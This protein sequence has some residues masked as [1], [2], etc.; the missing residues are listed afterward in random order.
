MN[1]TDR[2][3]DLINI[4]NRLA[5]LLE[6][7]NEALRKNRPQAVAVMLEEKS[8]LSRAY[9]ARVLGL[10]AA[11]DD[12]SSVDPELRERL[13]GLGEKI[14]ALMEDNARYLKVAMEV[15]KRV[16]KAIADAAKSH[17]PGPK[18]YSAKG[19]TKSKRA[20]AANQGVA[21]SINR[22]L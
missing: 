19:S 5:N 11:T 16:M 20:D 14:K 9:E 3:N 10:K 7:E 13:R 8:A 22:S 12:I 15:N 18:T 6:R 4:S 17:K 21:V 2:I 1:A